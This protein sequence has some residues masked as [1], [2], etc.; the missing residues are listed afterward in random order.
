LQPELATRMERTEERRAGRMEGRKYWVGR[1]LNLTS[2][3]I[4]FTH[5]LVTEHMDQTADKLE[6]VGT[7]F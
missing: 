2:W 1:A 5:F 3:A 6:Q 7:C 4:S